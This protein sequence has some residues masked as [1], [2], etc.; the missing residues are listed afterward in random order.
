MEL[1]E[2]GRN[3]ELVWIDLEDGYPSTPH[4]LI[5]EA[6]ELCGLP[7]YEREYWK[8]CDAGS[9]AEVQFGDQTVWKG[10][11]LCGT[12]MGGVES[13]GRFNTAFEL[14]LTASDARLEKKR[15]ECSAG[16]ATYGR[17]SRIS[18]MDDA[19]LVVKGEGSLQSELVTLYEDLRSVNGVM[20]VDKCLTASMK[21]GSF[22]CAQHRYTIHGNEVPNLADEG[23]T[24][25]LG[26]VYDVSAEKV[27]AETQHN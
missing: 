11:V 2:Q 10:R 23:T 13:P 21:K 4:T 6:E 16:P 18:L 7:E 26:A 1:K 22:R 17:K 24:K 19:T 12:V 8:A 15:V 9:T 14:P 20:H 5:H 3:A 25:F 27:S